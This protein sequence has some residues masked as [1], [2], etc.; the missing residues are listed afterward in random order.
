M[1]CMAL[2]SGSFFD[3]S[4]M[5]GFE[6]EF[7]FERG[8]N[9]SAGGRGGFL[10]IF[11]VPFSAVPRRSDSYFTMSA[12]RGTVGGSDEALVL[13][14]GVGGALFSGTVGVS[15]NI[16]GLLLNVKSSS[17]L[18]LNSERLGPL[19]L[20]GVSIGDATSLSNGSK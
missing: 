14:Q 7:A 15:E 8:V 4:L 5:T 16:E 10:D 11:S 1:S 17:V 13:T 9:G 6:G 12:E 20:L 3:V 2:E 19:R 18:A